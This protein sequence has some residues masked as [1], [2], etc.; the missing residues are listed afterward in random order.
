MRLES[1]AEPAIIKIEPIKISYISL[2]L[3][4]KEMTA[5]EILKVFYFP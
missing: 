1:V 4:C 2:K 5:E 3:T